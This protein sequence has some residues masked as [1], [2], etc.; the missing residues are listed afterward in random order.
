M[1][2]DHVAC[3]GVGPWIIPKYLDFMHFEGTTVSKLV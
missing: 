1:F 3:A 2:D